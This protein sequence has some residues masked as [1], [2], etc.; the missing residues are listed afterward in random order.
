MSLHIVI[1]SAHNHS[2]LQDCL[3]IADSERDTLVLLA[4]GLYGLNTDL[5]VN[6][7]I[8]IFYLLEDAE[9]RGIIAPRIGEPIDYRDLVSLTEVHQSIST[10]H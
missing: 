10:W 5:L 4:D 6:A 9:A 1:S 7:G 2:A 3:G 8:Q